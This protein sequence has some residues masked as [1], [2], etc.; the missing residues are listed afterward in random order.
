MHSGLGLSELIAVTGFP[1]IQQ[2]IQFSIKLIFCR[3]CSSLQQNASMRG[4]GNCA[5]ISIVSQTLNP[6]LYCFFRVHFLADIQP[7]HTH[8]VK[9]EVQSSSTRRIYE[10]RFTNYDLER[11]RACARS[12]SRQR[13]L[14]VLT[15][16]HFTRGHSFQAKPPPRH[17]S[18]RAQRAKF[19][20][21]S[22]VN[23][24]S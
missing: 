2:F 1:L 9:C 12:Y 4:L 8:F 14:P 22:I 15:Q 6:V 18:P 5:M 7:H 16:G 23:R 24:N 11:M 20:K 13:L 10:L 3:K 21:S 17:G 19:P